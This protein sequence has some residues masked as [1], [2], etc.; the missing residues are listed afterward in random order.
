MIGVPDEV[1]AGSTSVRALG[2]PCRRMMPGCW[3]G[4]VG[5]MRVVVSVS[6]DSSGARWEISA[7]AAGRLNR[8]LAR[9]GGSSF[10][11]ALAEAEADY[12]CSRSAI[13]D[14]ENATRG[15]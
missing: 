6:R 14:L 15:A 1:I 10:A 8:A 13:M 12:A 7:R 11:Q 9:G 3:A 5:T 4:V 2:A